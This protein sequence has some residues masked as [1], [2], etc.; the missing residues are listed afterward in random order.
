LLTNFERDRRRWIAAGTLLVILVL[1][2][3]MFLH[4]INHHADARVAKSAPA[5]DIAA[6]QLAPAS[7]RAHTP[8]PASAAPSAAHGGAQ[9]RVVAFTY[10]H[11]DQAQKKASSLAVKHPDLHPEVFSVNGRTPWLVT[12]GGGLQR[13]DAYA[14]ARKARSLGLPRDTYAQ[15]YAAR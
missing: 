11:K 15:N 8:Q 5:A 10:N 9:W 14:L 1:I 2:G 12:I 6:S 13:D 4:W 7:S 3:W